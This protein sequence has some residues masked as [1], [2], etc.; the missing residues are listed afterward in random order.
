[1][2]TM[3]EMR[4]LQKFILF[5]LALLCLICGTCTSAQNV[6]PTPDPS[7]YFSF[8][9]GGG[10]YAADGSG[11]G[12]TGTLH[13][14]S[15][16]ENG[17]CG[18]SVFFNGAGSYIEIPFSSRNH[19]TKEITV[20]AWFITNSFEPRVII[21]TYED[22]GYQL[23][24]DDGEDLWWTL[25]L[26]DTGMVSLP[27]RHESISLNEWHHITGTYDGKTMKMYLDGVLRNQMNATG[28][29]Q[30]QYNNYVML[31]A[32]AGVYNQTDRNCPLYFRGMLDEVRIYDIAL[33]YSQV[34]DD[35]FGCF[36]EPGTLSEDRLIQVVPL[37]SCA[38]SSG[39][40]IIGVH[41][42]T[43]RVLS[44]R[45]QTE[46]GIWNVTLPPG[47]TLV[48]KG[49]DFYSSTYPDAWYIEMGDENGRITRSVAFPNRNNA[50]L[51]GVVPSGNATVIIRYFDGNGR[52]PAK[53][54]IDFE[55]IDS[56]PPPVSNQTILNYPII[57][58][59][60][61]SW[62]TLIAIIL[63]M[64]W[65]HRRRKEKSKANSTD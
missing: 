57:V 40:V 45:N 44:V 33:A 13:G 51:K 28:E 56:P 62:A 41:E 9:E 53:V 30:Y 43:S 6:N 3:S 36:P 52:F 27:I 61:V 59:Y 17:V 60:S 58:I 31:G 34:M 22:G 12:N 2:I 5:S 49:H 26:R 7:F 14:I 48:V 8:N 55:S 46:N 15:R 65:L 29:I 35:R 16:S 42:K 1:M 18:K 10:I 4:S 38:V 64:V 47:S 20:S 24:F 54:A 19:P 63:V 32:D 37:S 11:N 23:G 50:P 39:S 21:S 25:N